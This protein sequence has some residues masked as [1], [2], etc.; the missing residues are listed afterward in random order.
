VAVAAQTEKWPGLIWSANPQMLCLVLGLIMGLN[1]KCRAGIG[2]P[3][4][5]YVKP[6]KNSWRWLPFTGFA[7]IFVFGGAVTAPAPQAATAPV[8]ASSAPAEAAAQN[9]FPVTIQVDAAKTVGAWK[10]VWRFFGADEPNYA[11]LKDGQK[12]LGEL[13]GL[14]AGQVY[15]RTHNL[16]TTGDGTPA[17]KWGSTNAYREDAKGNPIYDWTILDRIFDTYRD[18][19]VRPYVEIGFMPEAMSTNPEPYQHQW[20]IGRNNGNL[21]TGWI[22]PPKDYDKW[23]ELVYQ[24]TKHCVERYGKDEVEKWYWEVWNEPNIGYWGGTPEE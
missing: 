23:E 20:K 13:G 10:P 3:L 16:L 7:A 19:H 8:P 18:N 17:F 14:D 6:A 11:Y 4:M 5:N 15:F 12:L 22:Y 2:R 9:P 1:G 21:F 24:W